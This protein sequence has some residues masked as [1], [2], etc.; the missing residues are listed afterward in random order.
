MKDIVVDAR[1][2]RGYFKELCNVSRPLELAKR[3][4]QMSSH[5]N[6]FVSWMND[7]QKEGKLVAYTGG[8][9]EGELLSLGDMFERLKF[10]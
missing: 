6:K 4:K 1:D 8:E 7:C 10:N 9:T 2:T 3:I 5:T